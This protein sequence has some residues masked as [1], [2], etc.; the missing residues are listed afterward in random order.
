MSLPFE[1][2]F[3]PAG[4]LEDQSVQKKKKTV[5]TLKETEDYS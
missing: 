4:L 2:L 3:V 1:L 5:R